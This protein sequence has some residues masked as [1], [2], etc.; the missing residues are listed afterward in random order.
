MEGAFRFLKEAEAARPDIVVF[1]SVLYAETTILHCWT[2]GQIEEALKSTSLPHTVLRPAIFF[3]ALNSLLESTG[4]LVAVPIRTD[5]QVPWIGTDDVGRSLA[6]VMDQISGNGEIYDLAHPAQMS[7]KEAQEIIRLERGVAPCLKF[8]PVALEEEVRTQLEPDRADEFRSKYPDSS[9]DYFAPINQV[10]VT[11]DL[12]EFSR[13]YPVT[14][15][16]PRD[17]LKARCAWQRA[18]ID[19]LGDSRG[20]QEF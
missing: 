10:S 5:I 7:L 3:R 13:K 9:S 15:T 18:V 6:E 16:D 4:K 8:A 19:M 11:C 20:S 2:K 17:F 14:L 12:F 1:Q